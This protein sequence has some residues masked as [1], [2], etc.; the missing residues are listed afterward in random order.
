MLQIPVYERNAQ[1]HIYEDIQNDGRPIVIY[2]AGEVAGLVARRLQKHGLCPHAFAV[3]RAYYRSGQKIDEVPVCCY[4]EL[5]THANDYI[6]LLGIGQPEARVRAFFEDGQR[7][8]GGRLSINT[9]YGEFAPMNRTFLERHQ[10]ALQ[11]TYAWLSDALSKQTMQAYLN[12]KLSG[13]LRFNFDVF[14][15]DQY[16]NALTEFLKGGLFVDCGAFTGDT[17][18]AFVRWSGGTCSKIIALEPDAE[19]YKALRMRTDA[20]ACPVDTYPFGAWSQKDVLRF[21]GEAGSSSTLGEAGMIE[22][23]VEA[24]DN[25]IQQDVDFIK[26]DIEGAEMEALSG[27]QETIR[28]CH[29]AL[30]IAAYHKAEDLIT[31]PQYIKTFET[32]DVTYRFFLRKHHVADELELDLYALPERQ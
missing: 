11:E 4:E 6:F 1:H 7:C 10:E 3:D 22:V 2:G 9:P 31:I 12:L 26:M 15:A 18:E 19:N 20:L 13:D 16:F 8:G 5:Q 29:P 32:E 30:A 24:L 27:A 21:Q 14:R 17:A 23:P 25:L 28:R